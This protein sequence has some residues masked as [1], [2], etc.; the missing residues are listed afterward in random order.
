[1]PLCSSLE[2]WI[3]FLRKDTSHQAATRARIACFAVSLLC[4]APHKGNLQLRYMFVANC[5]NLGASVNMRLLG[6]LASSG[7]P[8]LMEVEHV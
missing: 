4:L 6:H 1:M 8:M 7:A 3:S 2:P 5:D